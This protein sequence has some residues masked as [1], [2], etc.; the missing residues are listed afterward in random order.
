MDLLLRQTS[1]TVRLASQ[2]FAATASS[3]SV[4]RPRA[5]G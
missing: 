5:S 3:W 1:R 4:A 2:S